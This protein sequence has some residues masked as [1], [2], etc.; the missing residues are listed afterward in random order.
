M[1]KEGKRVVFIRVSSP[2]QRDDLERQRQYMV[3]R[4]PDYEVVE[5]IGSGINWKRRGLLSLLDRSLQGGLAEVVV[6]S[7]DRLCR[8]LQ[9]VSRLDV[10][11]DGEHSHVTRSYTSTKARHQ[12]PT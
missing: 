2:K 6:A 1:G 9:G 8:F 7:R 11:D 10:T 12:S 5:D 4:F 3:A